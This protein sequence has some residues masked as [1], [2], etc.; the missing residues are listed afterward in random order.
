ML[1]ASVDM[2]KIN[3]VKQLLTLEFEMKDLGA[4]RMILGIEIDRDRGESKLF[5]SQR[6]YMQGT[7]EILND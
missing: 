5:L 6:N 7:K 2:A 4:V 3:K 1:I